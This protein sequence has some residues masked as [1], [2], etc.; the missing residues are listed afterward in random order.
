[1]N[2]ISRSL[3]LSTISIA[4]LIAPFAAHAETHS[5]SKEI[6]V[7]ESRDLPELAQLPGNSFF[8]HSD[9]TGRTYLYVEQL[10]GARLSVFDVTDPGRIRL[11]STTEL[12]TPGVFDFVEEINDQAELVRFRS[13]NRVAMLNLRSAAKPQLQMTA[14][15]ANENLSEHLGPTAFLA[16]NTQYNYIPATARDLQVVDVSNPAAPRL[17]ATIKNVKHEK[18]NNETGTTFLLGS[19]GLT[20][21]RRLSVEAEYKTHQMQMQ[22]N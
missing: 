13:D 9:N 17:L 8:L 16:V 3:I 12:H 6:V 15:L 5:K 20:V 11:A 22:G 1:M 21:V 10:Q 14:E 2:L 4:T 18:V 7:V 19:N